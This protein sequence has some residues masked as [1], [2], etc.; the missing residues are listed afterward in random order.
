MHNIRVN[1]KT[2]YTQHFSNAI[3]MNEN[4]YINIIWHIS[5]MMSC[6][7]V[8]LHNNGIHMIDQY[9]T[10]MSRGTSRNRS[11]FTYWKDSLPR[12]IIGHYV[13]FVH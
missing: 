6:Y 3:L 4:V 12:S 7:T 2:I 11:A 9:N 13:L 8:S 1:K 5:I 10:N